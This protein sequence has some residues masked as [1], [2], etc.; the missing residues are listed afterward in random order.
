MENMAFQ[1]SFIRHTDIRGQRAFTLVEVMVA[2]AISSL[3]LAGVVTTFLLL[4]RTGANINNYS[5]AEASARQAL[6][7]F[8]RE[9]HMAYSVSGNTTTSVTLA[10]PDTTTNRTGN[11]TASGAYLVTYNFDTD[12]P[13][14]PNCKLLTR[15]INSAPPETLVKGV[16][17]LGSIPFINYYKLVNASTV[18]STGEGYGTVV[19]NNTAGGVAEIRQIEFSFSLTR[20]SV[21]VATATNKVISARFIL[22]NK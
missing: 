6:E 16:K 14:N 2:A 8:S 21:T 5:E 20:K 19:T 10:L 13:D 9:A 15:T 3:M 18:P 7:Q 12:D 17:Q 4:G 22:R 11:D 1:T